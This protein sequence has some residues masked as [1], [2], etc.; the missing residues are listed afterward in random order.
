MCV[1]CQS[2]PMAQDRYPAP[3]WVALPQPFLWCQ[4]VNFCE[5]PTGLGNGAGD[6]RGPGTE[7]GKSYHGS[8]LC[9]GLVNQ[10][11]LISCIH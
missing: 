2:A 7:P 6:G 11:L 9:L 10:A 3:S 5:F 1:P 8:S 4:K